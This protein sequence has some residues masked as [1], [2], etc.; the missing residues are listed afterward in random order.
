MALDLLGE[1]RGAVHG[2]RTGEFDGAWLLTTLARHIGE[3]RRLSGMDI[4][5]KVDCGLASLDEAGV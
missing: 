3:V 2:L 1:L 5:L 4:P